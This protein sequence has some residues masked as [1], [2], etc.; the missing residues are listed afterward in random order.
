VEWLLWI[1]DQRAVMAFDHASDIEGSGKV[2][3]SYVIFI[4]SFLGKK[5]SQ[6]TPR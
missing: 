3:F 1:V 2:D 5:Y 6:P 4:S